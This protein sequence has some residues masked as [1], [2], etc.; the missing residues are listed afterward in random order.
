MKPHERKVAVSLRLHARRATPFLIAVC[1]VA[2]VAFVGCDDPDNQRL[3]GTYYGGINDDGLV[4]VAL[5]A[6]GNVYVAGRTTS[7]EGIATPGA[8]QTAFA[9]GDNDAYVAK[10]NSDGVR[11]W[12]TYLGGSKNDLAEGIAVDSQ[13]NVY[14]TGISDSFIPFANSIASPGAH[15]ISAGSNY[16][17]FVVKFNSAGVRQ[18]GTFFG[19]DDYDHGRGIDVD[20]E[21]N[22]YAVGFTYSHSMIASGNA[23][24]NVTGGSTDAFAVKFDSAGVLRWATYYGG[25][26]PDIGTSV[27]AD[28]AG[29]VYLVGYTGSASSISTPGSHQ[30]TFESV[31]S[32]GF[33]DA[34]VAKFDTAGARQW[35]TYYGGAG[36]DQGLG[37][38]VDVSGNVCVTGL[39]TSESLIATPGAHKLKRGG[40]QDAFVVKFNSG[41]IRQWG[42]YYGS[43]MDERGI[44]ISADV[45]GNVYFVGYTRSSSGIASGNGHQQNYRGTYD[46]SFAVKLNAAGVRQW[47][48]YYGD[49]S[50]EARAARVD[51]IGN[52]YFVGETS[53]TDR[54]ATPGSH[55]PA[56]AAPGEDGFLVKMS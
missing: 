19:G 55:Q 46:C 5:D 26:G 33:K 50:S 37:V 16:D 15:K 4:A 21:G 2:T 20:R 51:G 32:Q 35:A 3:W 53:D 52:L 11:Q 23:H 30:P 49:I 24:Q 18:W 56:K 44:G 40:G 6:S 10:F 43:N 48:T 31:G 8:H 22:V 17:A 25:T 45:A 36:D 29:G 34:F 14:V 28:G 27:A 13:G 54:I 1:C 9:G 47:A 39:T 7:T 12:G 38:T 42:T 41:G